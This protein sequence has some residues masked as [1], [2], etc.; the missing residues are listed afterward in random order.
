MLALHGETSSRVRRGGLRC[1]CGC[2]SASGG[3]LHVSNEHLLLRAV[4]CVDHPRT[5][6][7]PVVYYLKT[8]FAWVPR[9]ILGLWGVAL[10]AAVAEL[11]QKLRR[12]PQHETGQDRGYDRREHR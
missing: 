1:D 2:P 11:S 7:Y 4:P 3:G 5:C 6:P 12:Q 8:L 9:V 10:F